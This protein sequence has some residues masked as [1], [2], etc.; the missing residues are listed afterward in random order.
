MLAPGMGSLNSSKK[1]LRV[2]KTPHHL[3]K[4]LGKK[5]NQSH[6]LRIGLSTASFS[7]LVI[8]LQMTYSLHV[9]TRSLLGLQIFHFHLDF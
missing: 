1:C 6:N 3:I 2:L 9:S 7:I 4:E 8:S 5:S